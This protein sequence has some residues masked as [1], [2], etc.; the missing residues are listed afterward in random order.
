MIGRVPYVL[1]DNLNEDKD[2]PSY[3]VVTLGNEVN[4]K[5]CEL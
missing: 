2:T 3:L 5:Y 1:L 4:Y